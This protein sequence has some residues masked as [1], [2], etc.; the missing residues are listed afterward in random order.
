MLLFSIAM[1]A[2]I[3]LEGLRYLIVPMDIRGR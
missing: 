2:L 3:G 1:S